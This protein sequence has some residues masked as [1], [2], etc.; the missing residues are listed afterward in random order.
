MNL[1]NWMQLMDSYHCVDAKCIQNIGFCDDG[2]N[3]SVKYFMVL[4]FIIV[5]QGI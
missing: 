1:F 3:I 2:L 4:I 5:G